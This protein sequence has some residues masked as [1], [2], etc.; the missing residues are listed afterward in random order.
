[1]KPGHTR[2]IT[3]S[4]YYLHFPGNHICSFQKPHCNFKEHVWTAFLQYDVLSRMSLASAVRAAEIHQ[5]AAVADGLLLWKPS[6]IWWARTVLRPPCHPVAASQQEPQVCWPP[7]CVAWA[8]PC[9][10][11]CSTSATPLQRSHATRKLLLSL[12][13]SSLPRD[14]FSLLYNTP[15]HCSRICGDF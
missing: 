12:T 2:T 14:S 15:R 11:P 7:A 4:H 10:I 8:S 1:M 9:G 5:T 13:Y 3:W 6:D